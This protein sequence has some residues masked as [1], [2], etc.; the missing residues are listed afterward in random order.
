MEWRPAVTA[1]FFTAACVFAG[2]F[3][4]PLGGALA[5]RVR[6]LKPDA[7]HLGCGVAG[8]AQDDAGVDLQLRDGRRVHGDALVGGGVAG[9]DHEQSMSDNT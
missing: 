1:G 4:R 9:G 8:L 7:I 3:I 5:D 2:S 6:A